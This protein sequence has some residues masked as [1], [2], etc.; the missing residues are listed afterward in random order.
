MSSGS[1][2]CA[3]ATIGVAMECGA[4]QL[5]RIPK[6]HNSAPAFLVSPTTACL[7]AA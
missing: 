7:A 3:I 4:M 1:P 5:T 2:R 6:R